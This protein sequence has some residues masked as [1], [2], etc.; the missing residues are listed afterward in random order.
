MEDIDRIWKRDF[1]NENDWR[2]ISD[3]WSLPG[4]LAEISDHPNCIRN[5]HLVCSINL[6][7]NQAE[8]VLVI[9]GSSH[10]VCIEK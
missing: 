5:Q 1:S 9:C 2:D 4:Y 6:L 8:K 10:V 3:P 7:L